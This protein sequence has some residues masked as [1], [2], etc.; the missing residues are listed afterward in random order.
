M[1]ILKKANEIA[2]LLKQASDI[3]VEAKK[4]AKKEE[5]EDLDLNNT[6]A[7]NLEGKGLDELNTLGD[8]PVGDASP[9]TGSA[10]NQLKELL[11]KGTTPTAAVAQCKDSILGEID[12][13]PALFD[14]QVHDLLTLVSQD[15]KLKVDSAS[16]QAALESLKPK[17]ETSKDT[18]KP[19]TDPLAADP[20]KPDVA[21]DDDLSA[22]VQGLPGSDVPSTKEEEPSAVEDL[23]AMPTASLF[24]ALTKKAYDVQELAGVETQPTLQAVGLSEDEKEAAR[25]WK[26]SLQ[27]TL[28]PAEMGM[29]YCE[30][31]HLPQ[32]EASKYTE[33]FKAEDTGN[34]VNTLK[35][36]QDGLDSFLQEAQDYKPTA[37]VNDSIIELGKKASSAEDFLAKVAT[38]ESI[39]KTANELDEKPNSPQHPGKKL[40]NGDKVTYTDGKQQYF[41]GQ[42]VMQERD[43]G[44]PAVVSVFNFK[45]KPDV[46]VYNNK[47]ARQH[48]TSI[49]TKEGGTIAFFQ[50][51]HDKPTDITVPTDYTGVVTG[52]VQQKPEV[53]E[54]LA[55][56][57]HK[58][59]DFLDKKFELADKKKVAGDLPTAKAAFQFNGLQK[60]AASKKKAFEFHGLT[61]TAG[62]AD[63]FADSQ[64][65]T[66]S[67][68]TLASDA[69]I[70]PKNDDMKGRP[71]SLTP[72][73]VKEA[74]EVFKDKEGQLQASAADETAK[75]EDKSPFP[76]ATQDPK[77]DQLADPNTVDAGEY[78]KVKQAVQSLPQDKLA[79]VKEV[80]DKPSLFKQKLEEV[81]VM[82]NPGEAL[83]TLNDEGY[84]RLAQ[85]VFE[86][87]PQVKPTTP[88]APKASTKAE[89]APKGLGA[90]DAGKAKSDP[91]DLDG[92]FKDLGL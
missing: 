59:N 17:K 20:A 58:V 23:A 21:T 55:G 30:E 13:D 29:K 61:K 65:Q 85:E 8:A 26:A 27:E 39:M 68:Q 87:E 62:P 79:Q 81:M 24:E 89:D 28:V 69:N 11:S 34:T 91:T 40:F 50:P 70:G 43:G 83:P 15:Q 82:T 37:S 88:A 64:S 2:A 72:E 63:M 52:E 75:N 38:V 18:E 84:K 47:P 5:L 14:Q 67:T 19:A 51:I 46:D 31:N 45:G 66:S 48:V 76:P 1:N 41:P 56:A 49:N 42:K 92:L 7:P 54:Q 73:Q 35:D 71:T 60:E 77:K 90:G 9:A 53:K 25:N 44:N 4:K 22:G 74:Q 36:K 78:E 80:A 16:L 3:E 12:N 33:F 6:P 57:G 10:G 32:E 86:V